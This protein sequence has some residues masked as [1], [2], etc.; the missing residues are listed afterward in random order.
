MGFNSECSDHAAVEAGLWPN[1]CG[2]LSIVELKGMMGSAVLPINVE[3]DYLFD[4][5][6]DNYVTIFST[7]DVDG[8]WLL[9]FHVIV[10]VF[11]R[12]HHLDHFRVA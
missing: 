8:D 3:K 9:V 7:H 6:H 11:V 5:L 12:P 10:P 1:R 4:F 2:A